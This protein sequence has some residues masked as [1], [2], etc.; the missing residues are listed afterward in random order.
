MPRPAMF[1]EI[2][3]APRRPASAMIAASWASCRAFSTRHSTPAAWSARPSSSDSRT[4]VVPTRIGRPAAWTLRDLAKQGGVLR[5][6]AGEHDVRFV[7]APA[8]AMGREDHRPQPEELGEL[9]GCG[10]RRCGHAGQVPVEPHEV[11]H[12][13][14]AEDPAFFPHRDAFHRFDRRLD[15]VRPATVVSDAA[16]PLVDEL[17][18]AV[19]DDV[20]AVA[21]Q[22]RFRMQSDVHAAQEE[23]L[24]RGRPAARPAAHRPARSRYR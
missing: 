14:R 1:V 17:D 10:F 7:D 20:V 9:P 21:L 24:L 5:P 15:A 8:G 13:D 12:R 23:V 11:L 3:T 19:P 22:Q 4:L 18:A 2:V 16:G 6:A